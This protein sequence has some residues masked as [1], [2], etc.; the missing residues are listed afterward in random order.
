MQVYGLAGPLAAA[1]RQHRR[2]AAVLYTQPG[3]QLLR[4]IAEPP[5]LSLR[6]DPHP[7]QG[8]G[9][10]QLKLPRLDP[11]GS[12]V[13]HAAVLKFIKAVTLGRQHQAGP[14]GIA[15]HLKFHFPLHIAA[16]FLKILGLHGRSPFS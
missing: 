2:F 1:D 14:P 16:V 15:I 10:E 11:P 13:H 3:Q 7:I 5:L 9:A 4:Q 12:G 6:G 8:I